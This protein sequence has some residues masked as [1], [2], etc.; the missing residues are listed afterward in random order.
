[1]GRSRKKPLGKS[2]HRWV[3]NTEMNLQEIG[4]ENVNWIHLA[5]DRIHWWGL[6]NMAMNLHIL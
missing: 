1:M 4:S 5:Q 6:V 2:R 3:D